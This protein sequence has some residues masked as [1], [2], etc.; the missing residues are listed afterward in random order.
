[1]KYYSVDRLEGGLALLLGDDEDTVE[2]P[3]ARL[4]PADPPVREGD[5][6]ALRD[7]VWRRDDAETA[8]RRKKTAALLAHLRRRQALK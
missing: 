5:I 6:L 7:G 1:M 4:A 8:R 2:L 3:A